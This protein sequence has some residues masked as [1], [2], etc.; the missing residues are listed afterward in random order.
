MAPRTL[1]EKIWD[2][3]VVHAAEGEPDLLFIDLH[4]VHEVTSPQPVEGLRRRHLV[5]EMEVD[6][7]EVGL[8]LGRVDDVGVP[9]LLAERARTGG[10]QRSTAVMCTLSM[11]PGAWYSTVSPALRPTST[12]P[13]GELGEITGRSPWRSSMEPTKNRWVSPSSSPS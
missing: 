6:E 1:S 13:R 2:A 9:D 10:H 3:H 11:P 4:L 7:D 12:W 8:A 5:Q